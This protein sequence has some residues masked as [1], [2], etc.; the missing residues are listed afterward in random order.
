MHDAIAVHWDIESE[1][2]IFSVCYSVK[3]GCLSS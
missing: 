2:E 1:E 3:D